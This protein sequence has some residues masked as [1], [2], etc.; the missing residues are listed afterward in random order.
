MY[1]RLVVLYG[2][3]QGTIDRLAEPFPYPEN[4]TGPRVE[5]HNGKGVLSNYVNGQRVSSRVLC[6]CEI[7]RLG[8][9]MMMYRE[10]PGPVHQP[11]PGL[12]EL[13]E[14]REYVDELQKA[15]LDFPFYLSPSV[16]RTAV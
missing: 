1:P 12:M 14:I 8:N 6:D 9:M 7:L 2:E 13:D 5:L 15:I 4:E 3:L 16:K 10:H 11:V